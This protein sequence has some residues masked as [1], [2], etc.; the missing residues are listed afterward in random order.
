MSQ[1]DLLL[2]AGTF[3]AAIA[4]GLAGFAFALI[5]SGIYLHV[6]EPAAATPLVLACSAA[7]QVI[8]MLRLRGAMS[9]RGAAPLLAGGLAGV[10]AGALLLA[11]V[12][13][14]PLKLAV[15]LFL[16]AYASYALLAGQRAAPLRRGAAA[17]VAIGA[18][19]GVMGGLAGLSGAVPTLWVT[20][21]VQGKEE[22]RAI[23]QP[24]IFVMQLYGLAWLGGTGL[25]DAADPRTFILVLPAVLAGTLVGL[26]LYA[27]VND[28][29]FRRIVLLLLLASGLSLVA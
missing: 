10:P 18:V 19:G 22:Q 16:V 7:A 3:V 21:C 2:L 1:T 28:A 29:L 27:R 5:V 26:A 8:G 25:L 4:S 15:G 9:W 12:P 24:Y 11:H 20:L 13:P 23:Y 6:L 14:G 17:D